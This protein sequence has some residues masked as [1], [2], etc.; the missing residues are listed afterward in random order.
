MSVW[1]VLVLW[2]GVSMAQSVPA[3]SPSAPASTTPA[4][5][6]IVG[7]GWR[8]CDYSGAGS[9][10][11]SDGCCCEDSRAGDDGVAVEGVDRRQDCV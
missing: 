5:T 8:G 2:S 1:V 7:K 4:P 10:G 3:V 6:P 11:S 9:T